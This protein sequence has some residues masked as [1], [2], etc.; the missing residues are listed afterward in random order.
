M[1]AIICQNWMQNILKALLPKRKQSNSS[2]SESREE[3]KTYP[4]ICSTA[5]SATCD[6][7]HPAC[8]MY[9]PGVALGASEKLGVHPREKYK[10][11]IQNMLLSAGKIRAK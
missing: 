10:V 1:E 7:Y 9:L 11:R 2:S 6:M 4:A 8:D 3:E 5:E